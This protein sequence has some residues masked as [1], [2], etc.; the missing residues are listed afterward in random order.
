[1]S[2]DLERGTLALTKT[3]FDTQAVAMLPSGIAW[4]TDPKAVQPR[5]LGGMIGVHYHAYTRLR[6]MLEEADPRTAIET[7]T[8][9]ETDCGLPDPCVGELAPTVPL[10]RD[11][12]ITKRQS[13]GTTTPQHYVELAA[14]LGW[15]VSIMECRPF[16][17]WSECNSF[18][19][20]SPDWPN[21]FLVRVRED[22]VTA[23]FFTCRSFCNEFLA[24]WGYNSLECVIR[25]IAP[26]HT[27][28]IFTYN[29]RYL[30]WSNW[31]DTQSIWDDDRSQ[32]KDIV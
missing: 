3:D 12:V 17:T 5:L 29:A 1:M 7:L 31:D 4:A 10:R 16:R 19:N 8:M 23:Q 6:I 9:W 25:A 24:V 18:L 28:V 30:V 21:T 11:D 20:T 15:T 13:S 26:A 27:N 32:W 14:K 2:D 22:A